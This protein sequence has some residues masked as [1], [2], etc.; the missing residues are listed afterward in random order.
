MYCRTY[1]RM[2]PVRDRSQESEAVDH[3]SST[4]ERLTRDIA[5]KLAIIKRAHLGDV[6]DVIPDAG[7]LISRHSTMVAS[8]RE[9]LCGGHCQIPAGMAWPDLEKRAMWTSQCHS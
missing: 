9:P 6:P 8:I 5:I 3:L 2:S 4:S 1:L 7:D